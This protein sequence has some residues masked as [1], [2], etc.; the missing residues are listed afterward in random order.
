MLNSIFGAMGQAALTGQGM[1]QT[2]P[3][4]L[5][6]AP[7]WLHQAQLAQA[8]NMQNAY[9]PPKWMLDGKTYKTAKDF[10]QA[11]WPDDAQA[12]LMFALKYGEE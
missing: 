12:R 4:Q 9:Q 7:Q 1:Y 10:A 3:S 11:I 8:H 2:H 6:N 5:Q